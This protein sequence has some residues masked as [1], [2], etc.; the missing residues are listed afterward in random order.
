MEDKQILQKLGME[1]APEE[2]QQRTLQAF[3][4]TVELRLGG[5]I[6]DLLTDEQLKEFR[7]ME[8]ASSSKEAIF[9]WLS[10]IVGNL[11]DLYDAIQLDYID[12]LNE[13]VADSM[14]AVETDMLDEAPEAAE[15]EDK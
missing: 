8:E 11:Q 1:G 12:E 3:I 13:Q 7:K 4:N 2:L 5:L 14:K 10:G 6:E 9:K 15:Q